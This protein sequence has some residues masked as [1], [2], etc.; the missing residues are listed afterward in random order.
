MKMMNRMQR[1]ENDEAL[2]ND[3]NWW[4]MMSFGENCWE[5]MKIVANNGKS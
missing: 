5:I 1:D 2:G 3:K 4:K